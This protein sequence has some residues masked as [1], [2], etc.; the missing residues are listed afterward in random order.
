MSVKLTPEQVF[1]RIRPLVCQINSPNGVASGVLL[2]A[3]GRVLSVMH[4]IPIVDVGAEKQYTLNGV[5]LVYNKTVYK[6]QF[7]Q[8][9]I[10]P[11]AHRLDLSLLQTDIKVE[12]ES[13]IPLLPADFQLKEGMKVYFAGFPLTQSS[14]TFHRGMISSISEDNGTRRFTIDGT[15][16]PGNSGGPVI[17][18]VDGKLYI[19]GI[20]TAEVA[21][22]DKEFLFVEESFA[23]LKKQ[24]G[25][26]M[27]KLGIKYADGI[28]RSTDPF[29]LIGIALSG[30]KRNLSTGIGRA[31]DARHLAQLFEG[32]VTA[33]TPFEDV[34]VKKPVK[35]ELKE[36]IKT[37]LLKY[38]EHFP[39]NPMGE[40]PRGIVVTLQNGMGS[41]T[42]LF[43]INPHNVRGY[44]KDREELYAKAAVQ[45][46]E[47][48]NATKTFPQNFTFS[49]YKE[50]FTATL[51]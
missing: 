45:F 15:V 32:A 8:K 38:M 6:P 27:M 16:V 29:D 21:D 26:N 33:A 30:I 36:G 28:C 41:R 10:G 11:N 51:Q 34:E 7:P 44:N 31:I 35:G 24:G 39:G 14:I 20:I 40:G 47:I 19:A 49:A 43:D 37:I 48:F 25:A 46:Y 5:E 50:T 23:L 42:Y 4:N 9:F 13:C 17:I 18:Q 3:S 2:N 1:D 12:E 22:L